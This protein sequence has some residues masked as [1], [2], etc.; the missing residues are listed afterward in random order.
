[1]E[2]IYHSAPLS[3]ERRTIRLLHVHADKD[4]SKAVSCDLSVIDLDAD[5]APFVTLSYVWN[6]DTEEKRDVILCGGQALSL[7]RN[8]HDAL[9]H[10]RDRLGPFTIWIDAI[11]IDQTNHEE[12]LNQVRLMG[13]IYSKA[14]IVYVWLGI[15]RNSS[16][17]A[18]NFIE[19]ARFQHYFRWDLE[20]ASIKDRQLELHKAARAYAFGR[21]GWIQESSSSAQPLLDNVW[22]TRM[23]TYQEILLASNPILVLGNTHLQWSMLE[24]AIVF[25]QYSGVCGGL[26]P[27][28]NR[29]LE[30]W[31]ELVLGRD[32]LHAF[33]AMSSD[34]SVRPRFSSPE[35]KDLQ[36]TNLL[37]YRD[38]V[39][40]VAEIVNGIKRSWGNITSITCCCAIL[41]AF[42]DVFGTFVDYEAFGRPVNESLHA[43]LVASNKTFGELTACLQACRNIT[44]PTCIYT[45]KNADLGLSDL[46]AAKDTFESASGIWHKDVWLIAL[47]V[48]FFVLV[49]LSV[50]LACFSKSL[51]Q[52]ATGP[53][54]P[55]ND[56]TLNLVKGLC[57]R[58]CTEVKDKALAVQAVLQRLSAFELRLPDT[59]L[60]V[61]EVYC[62]L[63]RN[64]IEVTGSLA[65]LIPAA[66]K[67]FECCPS[68]A[69]DWS[70]AMDPLWISQPLYLG[71]PAD[72]TPGSQSVFSWDDQNKSILTVSGIFRYG[73]VFQIYQLLETSNRYQPGEL[74]KHHFNLRGMKRFL[75]YLTESRPKDVNDQL[76]IILGLDDYRSA[77]F[78]TRHITD[79]LS[80]LSET[81]NYGLAGFKTEDFQQWID[82]LMKFRL[83]DSI[84]LLSLL[85]QRD[86]ENS[87][88]M[89]RQHGSKQISYGQMLRHRLTTGDTSLAKI[90]QTHIAVCNAL[91][92]GRKVLFYTSLQLYANSCGG[93][94]RRRAHHRRRGA[95][96]EEPLLS[97][98][99]KL[100]TTHAIID[101]GMACDTIKPGDNLALICGV[102]IPLILRITSETSKLV[103]MRVRIL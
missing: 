11:C 55:P 93:D 79:M 95:E 90:W 18:L 5:H 10:L 20:S 24:R 38:S 65:L 43:L 72:A 91:A 74:A 68:W 96:V 99:E 73:K 50:S 98:N 81:D 69:P 80:M 63:S 70:A 62:E 21:L 22:L 76:S 100:D 67:H 59:T 52:R 9:R 53:V 44:A 77:G 40:E 39:I 41:T 8:G 88:K 94:P 78:E 1:M 60:P 85:T 32:R 15:G 17:R 3:H 86:V 36:Q 42:V 35:G 33:K 51:G 48:I 7:T 57:T 19:N 46:G 56:T 12:K 28:L 13:S 58:K 103:E 75:N 84:L 23:W 92:R 66:T 37:W 61:C 97:K 87:M 71:H 49:L 54:Y 29:V 31:T 16:N 30:A 89:Y 34:N 6:I 64:I 26:Q 47:P 83:I 82:Y 27:R 45:C 4:L 14:S 2:S 25:L 102:R 101:F